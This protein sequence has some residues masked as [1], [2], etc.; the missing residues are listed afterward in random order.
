MTDTTADAALPAKPSRSPTRIV[1]VNTPIGGRAW[2]VVRISDGHVWGTYPTRAK[3][4]HA[5]WY[6]KREEGA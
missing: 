5:V 1:A 3:A 4:R 2:Q 6:V